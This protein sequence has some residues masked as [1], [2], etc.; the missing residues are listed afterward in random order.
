MDAA[1]RVWTYSSSELYRLLV[2]KRGWSPERYGQFVV[3]RSSTPC[4]KRAI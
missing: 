3:T 1:E 2:I 4:W